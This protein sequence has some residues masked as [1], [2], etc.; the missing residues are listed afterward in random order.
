MSIRF[1]SANSFKIAEVRKILEPVGV[2]ITPVELDIRELQ[3]NDVNELVRDKCLKAF[4]KVKRP[5]FVEHTGLEIEALNGFPS[6]LTQLFW[7]TIKADRV[8]QLFG[9]GTNTKVVAKTTICFCDGKKLHIFDGSVDGFISHAPRGSRL[10][11]WDCV[12]IPS[13]Y[14]QTFAEMGER[15][16]EISMRR[17][18]LEKFGD[19]L[20][21]SGS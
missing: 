7:D 19:Y 2:N 9:C 12:F 20:S 17:L 8:S 1:I 21:G 3:T 16:N 14:E 13:G 4:H 6:G 5:L 18:A 10:F 11:Q 15:K